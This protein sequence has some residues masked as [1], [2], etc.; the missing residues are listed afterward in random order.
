MLPEMLAVI[1]LFTLR[2]IVP[3]AILVS[4]GALLAQRGSAAA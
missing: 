2:V 3:L 4:L 1:T